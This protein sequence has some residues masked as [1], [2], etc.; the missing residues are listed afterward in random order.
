MKSFSTFWVDIKSPAI[1]RRAAKPPIAHKGDGRFAKPGTSKPSTEATTTMAKPTTDRSDKLPGP[2]QG[3]ESSAPPDG[4]CKVST[5]I[6]YLLN[7]DSVF[8]CRSE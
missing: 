6:Y 1:E 2:D 5:Y 4:F 3:P 7:I 8:F